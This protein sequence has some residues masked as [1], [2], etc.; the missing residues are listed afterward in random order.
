VVGQDGMVQR[1]IV[2]LLS[3]GHVLLEGVPG[4]AKTLA[5]R[6]LADAIAT[7]FRRIQF[8][9]DLLPA[10]LIGTLIWEETQRRF[11]PKMG[12]IFANLV[13]ADEIN[14]APAKVQSALLEAMQERQVTIGEESHRVPIPFLVL[15]T[16]NPIE[17]EGTY[18]LPEAQVDRFMLKIR[19]DYPDRDQEREILRRVVTDDIEPLSPVA[20]PEQI[21]AARA[22]LPSVRV[23]PRVEEYILD[24]VRATREASRYDE[25]LAGW[26]DIGA[27]PRATISLARAARAQAFIEG[28]PFV[29]PEDI[30]SLALD[31][32][33]HRIVMTFEAEAE[34]ISP[35][36]VIERLLGIVPIP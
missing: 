18:P 23:D 25:E 26:I 9:P 15:A 6:S 14:R 28:R 16:Q 13:L 8:T 27:S 20:S 4:L 10:D 19:V 11:V 30:R 2:G 17:H 24:L 12:P 29:I 31:V 7:T 3:G 5:V 1:L 21:L 34:E 35:D 22:L 36:Q 33:R 32:L